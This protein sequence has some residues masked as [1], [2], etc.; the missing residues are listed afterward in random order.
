M[1]TTSILVIGTGDVL[2]T[3]LVEAVA[4]EFPAAEVRLATTFRDAMTELLDD[5]VAVVA[6][7]LAPG[8]DEWIRL[9]R[10]WMLGKDRLRVIPFLLFQPSPTGFARTSG[11][12]S[13]TRTALLQ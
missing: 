9:L 2:H 1:P 6:A 11:D 8:D 5:K 4:G 7:V 13:G 12:W 3:A 10:H